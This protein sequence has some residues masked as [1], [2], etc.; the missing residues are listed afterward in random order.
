MT[1]VK[2]KIDERRLLA[3]PDIVRRNGR[4]VVEVT[5]RRGDAK[6]K[7]LIAAP[8][9]GREYKRGS[10]THR[11]SAPGEPPATDLGNLLNGIGHEMTGDLTGAWYSTAEYSEILEFGGG[12]IAARP[13]MAPSAKAIEG[14]WQ[15]G[16]M[17]IFSGV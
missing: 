3:A 4:S 15:R 9:H 8:G 12:H 2:I 17:G 16:I 5:I 14:D 6:A 1:D 10:V 7:E 11:A 13:F